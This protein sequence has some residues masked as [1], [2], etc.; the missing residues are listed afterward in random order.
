MV[1]DI[2][3]RLNFVHGRYLSD[4]TGTHI[5]DLCLDKKIEILISTSLV[6]TLFSFF[7]LYL[8]TIST[9]DLASTVLHYII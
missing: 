6:N 7:S 3:R 2:V 4:E 1:H 5:V 9:S 8:H